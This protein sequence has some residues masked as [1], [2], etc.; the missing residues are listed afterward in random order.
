VIS[1]AQDRERRLA[2]LE[3]GADELLNKPLDLDELHARVRS[4]IRFKRLTDELES[5]ESLFLTLGRIV[6]ARDPYTEG[7]CE[8]LAQYAAALGVRLNL[9]RA[10][11]DTLYRGAFLHDIGKIAIPDQVLLKKTRLRP[12]EYQLIKQHPMMDPHT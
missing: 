5:A 3:A 6:E 1:A 7:H 12:R 8:R 11:L 2:R 4:L 10:D 9:E